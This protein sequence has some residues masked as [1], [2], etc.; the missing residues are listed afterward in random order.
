MSTIFS[1]CLESEQADAGLDGQPVSRD[2]VLTRE[3]GQR[4]IHIFPVQ[5]MTT[6]RIRK[7][8]L[9][10]PSLL[11]LMTIDT[12][13]HRLLLYQSVRNRATG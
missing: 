10:M 12:V 2:Q 3:E 8:A 7:F 6:S 9:L 11:K 1:Q 13:V 4:K 5:L